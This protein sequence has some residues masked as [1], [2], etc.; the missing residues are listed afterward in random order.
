[1][2]TLSQQGAVAKSKKELETVTDRLC[3][4]RRLSIS[5]IQKYLFPIQVNPVYQ[6]L[7][8]PPLKDNVIERTKGKFYIFFIFFVLFGSSYTKTAVKQS[9]KPCWK[10]VSTWLENQAFHLRPEARHYVWLL[11]ILCL[12]L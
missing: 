2:L 5:Q 8:T 12:L 11:A 4:V 9:K 1:M 3:E 6:V 10:F 7:G